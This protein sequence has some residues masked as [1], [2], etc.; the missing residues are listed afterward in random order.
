MTFTRPT[1]GTVS[2]HHK[3]LL[4]STRAQNVTILSS[5]IPEKFK[6]VKILKWIT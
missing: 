2:H 5:A 6:G 1:W 4:A 3:I